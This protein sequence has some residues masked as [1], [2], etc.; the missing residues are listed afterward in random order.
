MKKIV[1]LGSTGSVGRQALSVIRQYPQQFEIV[2]LS[3]GRNRDL[4][5]AQG[6]EFRVSHLALGAEEAAWLA[7][8]AACDIV[9]NAITGSVGLR[10]TVAAV[11]AGRTVALAN[12]E[13]LV[14]GGE[15]LARLA[16]PGQVISVDSEHSAIAQ[17]MRAGR[18]AE[19]N[20]LLITASG[21]PFY[22]R[23]RHEL[24]DV[25]PAEAM[26]HPTWDMGPMITIN[27][28]TLVN[29]GLEVLEARVLFGVALSAIDVV[30]H[31][32]SEVHSMVEFTDGSTIICASEPDMRLPIAL[33]LFWPYRP[34]E[35]IRALDW[36]TPREW[37]FAPV[38]HHT[39]PAIELAK[40]AG[41]EG[42]SYPAVYN[43]ANE[44]AVHAFRTGDLPFVSI[45]DA[46]ADALQ[47]HSPSTTEFS[48]DTIA[49][50][51]ASA[52]RAVGRFVRSKR[53]SQS[54]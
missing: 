27:S 23:K 53:R 17:A 32:Q 50:A 31:R 34:V 3:A 51:E 1:V 9:L 19:V 52:R 13:S 48:L 12:K 20:R 10:S 22:G 38:D 11:K 8:E 43:A 2:G 42:S 7:A 36:Y 37:T 54:D 16:V 46:I 40:E 41:R 26:R 44:E 15:L 39:F 28:A 6:R 18:A 35:A 45:T 21:G 24:R 49:D 29:K 14:V 47:R 5:Q 33:G 25:T 4:L 30:V